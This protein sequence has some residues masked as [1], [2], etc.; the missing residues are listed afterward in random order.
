MANSFQVLS[1]EDLH[2]VI[3]NQLPSA[4]SEE[5][6]KDANPYQM[7]MLANLRSRLAYA[8][9]ERN[10]RD[11]RYGPWSENESCGQFGASGEIYR[12]PVEAR[13]LNSIASLIFSRPKINA[14]GAF[15][16]LPGLS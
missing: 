1:D 9:Q 13:R 10:R 3:R 4:I 14:A 6:S 5:L 8:Q 11:L 2:D 15:G 7:R 16:R 12:P